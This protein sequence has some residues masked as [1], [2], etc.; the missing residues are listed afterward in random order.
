MSTLSTFH[1]NVKVTK[2]LHSIAEYPSVHCYTKN[3]S[4][5]KGAESFWKTIL[6]SLVSVSVYRSLVHEKFISIGSTEL[7]PDST[8]QT[9]SNKFS[10]FKHLMKN[11]VLNK[12]KF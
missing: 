7:S 10:F 1:S 4:I 3:I 11:I 12:I 9:C 2:K 6:T 8:K 5:L